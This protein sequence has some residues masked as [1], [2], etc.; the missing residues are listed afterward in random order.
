MA[1]YEEQPVVNLHVTK[2]EFKARPTPL[3][4]GVIVWPNRSVSIFKG[5]KTPP[6]RWKI[7]KFLAFYLAIYE[8][9]FTIYGLGGVSKSRMYGF[10]DALE[11][12]KKL[13]R[14]GK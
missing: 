1:D 6:L 2:M 5:R 4:S 14:R 12:W 13:F 3:R 8:C 7:M 9:H 10:K 11:K